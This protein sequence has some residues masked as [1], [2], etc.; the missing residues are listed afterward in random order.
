MDEKLHRTDP[1]F[2]KAMLAAS[3][4]LLHREIAR[5]GEVRLTAADF[6]AYGAA[7]ASGQGIILN[8]EDDGA[9]IILRHIKA[10]AGR[11]V[12]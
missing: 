9:T 2:A 10:D 5:T 11:V 1:E 6:E 8:T 3:Q 12:Q 4:V 7:E